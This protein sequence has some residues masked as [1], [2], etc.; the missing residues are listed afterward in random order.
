[1]VQQNHLKSPIWMHFSISDND[2]F[3]AVCKVCSKRI[4]SGGNTLKSLNTMNL[5]RH[6]WHH[7]E[8]NMNLIVADTAEKES[9]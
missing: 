1:M 3:R 5:R 9:K 8:E 2:N 7:A 6:L 4:P